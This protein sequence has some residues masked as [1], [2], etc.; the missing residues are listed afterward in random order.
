MGAS[1]EDYEEDDDDRI[2][3]LEETEELPVSGKKHFNCY[4]L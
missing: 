2:R 4:I 3:S 1:D